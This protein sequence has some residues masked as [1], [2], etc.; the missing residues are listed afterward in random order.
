MLGQ[1]DGQNVA[2]VLEATLIAEWNGL[3]GPLYSL[4][5]LF[6][7]SFSTVIR[8]ELYIEF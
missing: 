3:R 5:R 4:L 2:H 8:D 7:F 1:D 6:S